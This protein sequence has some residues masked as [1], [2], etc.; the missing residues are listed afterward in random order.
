MSNESEKM[1]LIHRIPVW[2]RIC[3][4][5]GYFL[6]F[7]LVESHTPNSSQAA[8]S[9]DSPA[10]E[11]GQPVAAHHVPWLRLIVPDFQIAEWFESDSN[12]IGIADR[13]PILGGAL[14]RNN[15]III[16]IM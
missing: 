3:A 5:L 15:F 1:D 2:V 13:I 6:L 12:R 9:I 14:L 4:V 10:T 8:D 7:S 11:G 16:D